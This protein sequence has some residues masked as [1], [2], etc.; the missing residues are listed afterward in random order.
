MMGDRIGLVP[1]VIT[2]FQGP[3]F[4]LNTGTSLKF[5]LGGN[6][7]NFQA[8]QIGTWMRI[9][10]H[11]QESVTADAVIVSTRFDYNDFSIGFSYDVNVSSLRPASNSNGAFEFALVYKICGPEKRN[12]YC[13][14]F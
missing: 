13:P 5:L 9:S 2:L 1:G 14:N 6:K 11:F 8:F 10:N 12:V 7:R 3:S 4:E